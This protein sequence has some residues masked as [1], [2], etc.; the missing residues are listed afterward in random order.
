MKLKKKNQFHGIFFQIIIFHSNSKN[1]GN[2]K[3]RPEIFEEE[4][5]TREIKTKNQFHGIFF[6]LSNIIAI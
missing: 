3:N 1:L 6:L 2:N 5:K 4:K